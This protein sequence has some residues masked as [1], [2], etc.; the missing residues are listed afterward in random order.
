MT[1]NFRYST[2]KHSPH[3]KYVKP[4]IGILVSNPEKVYIE[5]VGEDVI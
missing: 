3:I 2:M 5:N 4:Y 1:L